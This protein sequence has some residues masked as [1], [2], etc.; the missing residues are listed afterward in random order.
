RQELVQTLER[1]PL[2]ENAS[3]E[4]TPAVQ[5]PSPQAGVQTTLRYIR[6]NRDR[7]NH[8]EYRQLAPPI[9][10]SLIESTVNEINQLARRKAAAAGTR[11]C[12]RTTR[13]A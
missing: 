8:P 2:V 1:L 11:L 3:S 5:P 13:A 12:R 7:T 4:T 10:T 6:N 9:T